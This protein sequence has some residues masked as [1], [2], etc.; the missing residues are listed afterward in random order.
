[1]SYI[2][3]VIHIRQPFQRLFNYVTTPG[4]WPQ[5]QPSA[6]K[7]SGAT[8]YALH[9]GEK[10][11]EEFQMAG[12]R[13]QMTWI[14]RERQPGQRWVIEGRFA[15]SQGSGLI[16]YRFTPSAEGTL[17]EREFTYTLSSSMLYL[18]DRLLLHRRVQA[19]SDE[20]L[21]RLKRVLEQEPVLS[22]VIPKAVLN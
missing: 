16:T 4:T 21:R 3:S 10:V 22:Q 7:V 15:G 9:V 18:L 14:V 20:A 13:G 1:M 5:W 11:T 2:Y 17:L 19:E 6:L 8:D 12:R